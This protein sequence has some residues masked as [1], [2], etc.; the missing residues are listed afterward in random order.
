M[1]LYITEICCCKSHS[2]Q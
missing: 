1:L 2:H